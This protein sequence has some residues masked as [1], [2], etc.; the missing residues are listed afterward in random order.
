[1]LKTYHSESLSGNYKL[2]GIPAISAVRGL[3]PIGQ[4]DIQT[5]RCGKS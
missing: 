4:F 5:D 2:K 3:K 1:V